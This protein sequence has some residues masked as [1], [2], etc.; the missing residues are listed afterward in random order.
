MLVIAPPEPLK[1]KTFKN[2]PQAVQNIYDIGVKTAYNN[3][4]KI[5][6]FLKV[7]NN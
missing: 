3:L 1:V 5:R 2:S 7:E 4:Q 6:H